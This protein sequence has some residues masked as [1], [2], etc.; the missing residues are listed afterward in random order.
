MEVIPAIV[1]VICLVMDVHLSAPMAVGLL[2]VSGLLS[3]FLFGAM[4]QVSQRAMDW[5]DSSPE[6]G[7]ETSDHAA[8]LKEIAAN[9]AYAFLV[10]I[11]AAGSF[12][13]V[14][15]TSTVTV[16]IF[17][18]IGV[19]LIVH[20]A[21]VLFMIVRRVYGLTIERLNKARTNLE[22]VRH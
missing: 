3:A 15:V 4:L 13:V 22:S 1:L 5:A 8:F 12:V 17:S 16:R 21:L 19:A 11:V 18:A 10:S 14:S 9:S 7:E 6:P 2:T 20:L